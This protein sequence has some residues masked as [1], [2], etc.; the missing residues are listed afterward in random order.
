MASLKEIIDYSKANPTS[1]YAK[2][3]FEVLQS[4]G[5]DQQAQAEGIDLSPLGRPKAPEKPKTVMENVKQT[6][7]TGLSDASNALNNTTQN[8]IVSGFEAAKDV[9]NIA[10]KVAIDVLKKPV[11]TAVSNVDKMFSGNP[12]Y[13][14]TKQAVKSGIDNINK[15][16]EGISN[17]E[18]TAKVGQKLNEIATAH[19][20]LAS[21]V[22]GT[23]KVLSAGGDIANSILAVDGGAQLL[24]KLSESVP[25]IANTISNAAS[26][27][28]D[29]TKSVVSNVVPDS[30]TIMNRVARLKPTDANKFVD[31]SGGETHGE[32]L[33]RT[34]NFGTPDKIIANEASKFSQSIDSVDNE[35]AKLPGVYKDGSITDALSGLVK[36]A[37]LESGANVK[38][39]YLT[40]AQELLAKSQKEGLSMPEINEAKRLYERNVK[41][42]YNKLTNGDE[43]TK[44]TNIDDA[45]RKWQVGQAEKLGFKNIGELNKQTQL[46]KFIIDKLGDQIVG[47][48]GLNG[49]ELSDYILI[50]GGDPTSVASYLTKKFFSS[51]SVQSKIA[52]IVSGG[53]V[54]GVIK[55]KTSFSPEN[56]KRQVSPQGL[57]ELPAGNKSLPQSQNLVPIK[58]MG[59]STIEPQA[60][61]AMTTKTNKTGDVYQKDLKTGKTKII[62]KKK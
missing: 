57:M 36:K 19:P 62:P 51:A 34:G 40:R 7:S 59:E 56:V 25:A 53:K 48:S 45:L 31:L 2:K 38:S 8:P 29:T 35:L 37:K 55:P 13:D 27:A 20:D 60:Q 32:Y 24:S 15:L 11:E 1:D 16:K 9:A 21:A 54:D 52:K 4:G 30:S 18:F 3:A 50:A 41:L 44:A 33:S 28:V 22:D 49:F 12:L 43:V 6:V 10:P 5:F 26:A 17:S 58:V 61:N 39:P 42:G 23:L 47:K 14:V 46:S